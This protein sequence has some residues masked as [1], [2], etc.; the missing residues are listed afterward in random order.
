MTDKVS[1]AGF[2]NLN[3]FMF[4][5]H[6]YPWNSRVILIIQDLKEERFCRRC[7]HLTMGSAVSTYLRSIQNYFSKKSQAALVS[8]ISCKWVRLG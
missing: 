2:S 4:F 1:G 3:Q 6:N 5:T 7:R 8:S